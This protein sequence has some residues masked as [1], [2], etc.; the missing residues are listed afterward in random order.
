[1]DKKQF[2][3]FMLIAILSAGVIFCAYSPSV[4]ENTRFGSPGGK[5]KKL[6]KTGFT[7]LYDGVKKNP[8]WA[9]YALKKENIIHGNI[10][11]GAFKPDKA[12]APYEKTNKE[13]YPAK[14]DKCPMVPVI[15]MAGNLKTYSESFLL[16]NICPMNPAL[17]RLKWRELEDWVRDLAQKYG[18][19]WV[20]TGPV[21]DYK[22]AKTAVLGRA[23]IACPTGFY[24]VI[25]FQ[26]KDYSFKSIG[27]YM[28]NA[29]QDKPLEAYMTS[30]DDVEN[31]TGLDFFNLLPAEVQLIMEKKTSL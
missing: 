2:P 23:K 11:P 26:T 20:V 25:L 6:E 17:K 9:S 22:G 5:G 21:F 4:N 3:G 1:M 8:L 15:D 30:V 12:L 29:K 16:S 31:R 13:D 24:K 18:E 14:Y 28:D 27:F 7:L 19:L 10:K